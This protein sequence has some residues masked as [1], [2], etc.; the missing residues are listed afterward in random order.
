ME[1][2]LSVERFV[3]KLRRLM[4]GL[5]KPL[6]KSRELGFLPHRNFINID[7]FFSSIACMHSFIPMVRLLTRALINNGEG[8]G[9]A[10]L[11][12]SE[13]LQYLSHEGMAFFVLSLWA[14]V[15]DY[16]S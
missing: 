1:R 5:A 15:T 2:F 10:G 12:V 8:T 6:I 7:D 13:I 16:P 11:S 4:C 3:K 14:F 9:E